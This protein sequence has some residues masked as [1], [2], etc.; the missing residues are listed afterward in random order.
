MTI[1]HNK[2]VAGRIR[3]QYSVRQIRGLNAFLEQVGAFIF[4]PLANGLFPA[5]ALGTNKNYTGYSYIWVRDNIHI[6]YAHYAVGRAPVATKAVRTLM[7]YFIKHKKRFVDII[8]GMADPAIAMNRPH[9]R[10]DGATLGEV[11][12]KWAHAQND[13]LGYFLWLFCK[14]VNEKQFVLGQD[15]LDMLALFPLYFRTIRFWEDEDSGHWEEMRKVSASSIGAVVAGLQAFGALISSTHQVCQYKETVITPEFVELLL[16]RGN[17]ALWSILPAECMQPDTAKRRLYD[18]ALL[19]LIYPLKVIED[20]M[21]DRILENV[22]T[23]L[24]GEYGIRRYLG[25]S[26]W[27]PDYKN[28]LGP[29]QRTV[30]FSD[31]VSRRDQLL[32]ATGQEAQ[33]CIFDPIVSCIYG[34]RFA[35]TPTDTILTKQT[36]YLNRSLGQITSED[37]PPANASRCPELYYLEHGQYV[38]NDHVPLLWTQANLMLGL[39][40]MEESCVLAERE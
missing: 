8:E 33:W 27:A 19:F 5:A 3:S 31:D 29:E 30:D 34:T 1:I 37:S 25:D 16:R 26:Y 20:Q 6:A 22:R 21:A 17:E 24:Q 39:K 38:P 7:Q 13:A 35:A 9:I 40:R 15:E 4:R 14:L 18:S 32:S 11:A 23:H 36:E 12:E 2:Q 28:K 10:F